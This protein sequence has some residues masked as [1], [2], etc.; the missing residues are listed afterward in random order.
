MYASPTSE[1]VYGYKD[2]EWPEGQ[3]IFDTVHPDDRDRVHRALGGLALD[4]A[5]RS[6]RSRCACKQGRRLVDVHRGHRQ[7]PARRPGGQRDR[8][9]VARHHRAQAQ[10]RRRCARARAGCARARRAIAAC[11]DDQTE[12][13][14]RYRPDATLTF[15]NRAF[16]EFFGCDNDELAGV[17]LVDLRPASGARAC[18]SGSQSFSGGDSVRTH[19][20]REVSLDGSLRWY[21]WTDRAFV[22]ASGE[23]VEYQSVGHDVTD[24]RR[25]AE[26][27]AHQ[28]EILEQ[29]ARGVPLDEIAADDRRRARGTL[30]AVLVRHH[31]ARSRDAR[32]FGSA[33]RRASRRGSSKRSTAHRWPPTAGSCGAAAFTR[34]PVYVRDIATDD[35]WAEHRDLAQAHGIH[36]AWSIPIVASDGGAVLGTLDVF[37]AEPRLPDDQQRQIFFLLAQLA[38][39]AIERKAFEEQLAHQSMHDPLTGL[40]NRLL[41][42]DR[43]GQSI[44]RCQRTKSSVG[45]VFLDLD[46][47]KNINDSLGHDA[48]DEL[49]VA[50]ARKLAVGDPAR[51]HRRPVRRRRVHRALRGP[52]RTTSARDVAVEISRAPPRRPSSARW[53]CAAP[54]CSWAPASASRSAIVGRRAPRGAAAR[55]RRRDVPRQGGGSRAASR[56]STT[57]CA[58]APSPRTR[59]R[60]RCTAR[61]S[62]ASSG[63]SSSRSSASP[64]RRCVGAEALVRW[65][66]PERG[67]IGPAEFIPLA[68]ETG[69]IVP[70]G[71][72]VHRGGRAATRRAGS[73]SSPEPFQVVDQPLG[74]PARAARSR[75]PGR[76]GDRRRPACSRRAC[77]SRSPRAC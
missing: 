71:W 27:T 29:V 17:K 26:F 67:L 56:C 44:A 40:P 7:Q 35:G 70:I 60:T 63:S 74:P 9:H 20:E 66:H 64:T 68:E 51:R 23:V 13:V 47:F 28:A 36:A 10:A 12:L 34:E 32:R 3:S 16:A 53:S 62:A 6:A 5:A 2:G 38:S 18:S 55:R 46:R 50:V 57:R 11:V 54:R 72:W 77:A 45:V 76:R 4:A 61:S 14:C 43:L 59:P 19:V 30:P 75:R 48:G 39:I 69:L 21:Q 8:R 25:A 65:Q 73:S 42:I 37:V 52:A 22:D 24:Q 41:F 49:L 33:P 31:A 15:A 1:Q 58:R